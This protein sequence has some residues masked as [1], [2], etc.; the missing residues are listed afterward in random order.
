MEENIYD[1]SKKKV[2][3]KAYIFLLFAIIFF[4]GVFAK[5]TGWLKALDYS[6]ICGKFGVELRGATGTGAREGFMFAFI[7]IPAVALT[8]GI[9]NVVEGQ[10][11]LLAAQKIFNPIFKPVC[12]FPGWCGLAA[13]TNTLTSTDGGSALTNDLIQKKLINDKEQSIF[14]CFLYTA[15]CGIG[16]PLSLASMWYGA[17]LADGVLIAY[18]YLLVIISKVLGANLMRLYLKIFDKNK[19]KEAAINE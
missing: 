17:L 19:N 10:G 5:S 9:I 8:L 11:G 16:A 13:I 4:G 3:I 2:G 7:T 15:S 18:P 12:G 14:V 1:V 6:T